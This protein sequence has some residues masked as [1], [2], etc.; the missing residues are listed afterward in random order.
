MY[1]R[2][3]IRLENRTM[4]FHALTLTYYFFL[5]DLETCLLALFMPICCFSAAQLLITFPISS[6]SCGQLSK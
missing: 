5:S 2:T 4:K 1:N 6:H 3:R